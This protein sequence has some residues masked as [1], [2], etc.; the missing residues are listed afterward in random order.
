MA[1]TNQPNGLAPV[2]TSTG[3]NWNSQANLYVIPS[4]DGSQYGIGDIVFSKAGSDANGVP[5]IQKA[6]ASSVPRGILIGVDPVLSSGL[7]LQGNSLSLETLTIPATKTKAYYV[8]VVDDPTII[9]EIQGDNTTTLTAA[10]YIGLNANPVIGNPVSPSPFSSTV[11]NTAT[12]A[13]T[14]TFMLKILGLVQRPGA[15][16]TAYTRFLCRFN[17]HEYFGLTTG[18]T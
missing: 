3:A 13:T 7:S 14:S 16:F 4:T 15:D 10:S 18:A 9:F 2:R 17:A 8:Y 12:V 5:L 6:T 1:N 11:L